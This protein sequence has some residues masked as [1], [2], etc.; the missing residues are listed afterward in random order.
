MSLDQMDG[1]EMDDLAPRFEVDEQPGNDL[2]DRLYIDI[3]D[4]LPKFL[5]AANRLLVRAELG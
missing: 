1:I 5:S 2:G 4:V 3:T